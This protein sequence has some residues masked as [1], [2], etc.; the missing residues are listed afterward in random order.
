MVGDQVIWVLL[1]CRKPFRVEES[2]FHFILLLL[3]E[4][5]IP[6]AVTNRRVWMGTMDGKVLLSSFI[7]TLKGDDGTTSQIAYLLKI[8]SPPRVLSFGWT[9]LLGE[10]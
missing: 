6:M 3:A 10:A 7:L 8:S 2:K 1:F 5:Y 4:V 9:T